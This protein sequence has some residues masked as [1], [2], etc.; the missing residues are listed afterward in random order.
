MT[1]AIGHLPHLY[2]KVTTYT[3]NMCERALYEVLLAEKLCVV[4]FEKKK[5]ESKKTLL[6]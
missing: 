1:P 5:K 2:K 4:Y 3:M 6:K